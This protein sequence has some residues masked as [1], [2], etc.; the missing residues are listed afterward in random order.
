MHCV[1]IMI[2]FGQNS[3][4]LCLQ[5]LPSRQDN[6]SGHVGIVCWHRLEWAGRALMANLSKPLQLGTS[7]YMSPEDLTAIISLQLSVHLKIK[8]I[9][10][11]NIRVHIKAARITSKLGSKVRDYL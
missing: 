5:T 1:K 6:R 4:I 3:H 2:A 10:S 11:A 8:C 9:H 7:L